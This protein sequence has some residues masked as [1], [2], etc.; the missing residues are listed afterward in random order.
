V[1]PHDYQ[2]Q[3]GLYQVL[4]DLGKTEEAKEQLARAQD[5]KDRRERLAEISQ[6]KMSQRPYDPA[7]HC[8]LGTLL[9]SLG[10]RELG[11]GWLHG[12][13][14]KDPNYQP[15]HAALADYYEQEGDAEQAAYHRQ[16]AQT[17]PP[18]RPPPAKP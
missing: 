17:L 2:V 6:R 9:I 3:F 10:Y 11:A 14:Q 12:A 13:L 7:L 15:A 16:Q 18:P 1:L 8:E 5:V 4:E